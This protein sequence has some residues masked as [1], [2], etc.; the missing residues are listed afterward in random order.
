MIKGKT[1]E[2]IRKTFNIKND[3][4]PAEEEQVRDSWGAGFVIV[5]RWPRIGDDDGLRQNLK[6]NL[7]VSATLIDDSFRKI[8]VILIRC[9]KLMG[10]TIML[11]IFGL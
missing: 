7:V 5:A 9:R 11:G 2:E 1:P 10:L 8:G 6:F 3:F 4:T